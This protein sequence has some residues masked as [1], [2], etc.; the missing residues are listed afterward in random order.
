[1]KKNWWKIVAVVLVLYTIIAGFLVPVPA[2]PILHE[3]I[4]NLYFHVPMWFA[5]LVICSVSVINSIIYLS[6]PAIKFDIKAAQSAHTGMLLGILGLIT[7]SIWARFTWG[8]WWVADTKL[9][10]AAITML[11]YLAYFILRGSIEEEQ[12]R[13]RIAAVYNIFAYVLLIVFLMILPRMSDSLHPG[14]GGNPGFNKYDLDSNMRMVFYPAVAGWILIAV[15]LFKLR[16]RI[17][18]LQQKIR[19][20]DSIFQ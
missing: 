4:R 5:M 11:I 17:E 8:A 12:K 19:S 1:M 18:I 16:E 9:N 20:N 13:A 6:K 7:G 2:Q 3:S 15:W 10:G 14:N